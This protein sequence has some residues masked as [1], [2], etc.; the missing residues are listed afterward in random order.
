ME[1]QRQHAPLSEIIEL[2]FRVEDQQL[3]TGAGMMDFLACGLGGIRYLH[4][5]GGVGWQ[6]DVLEVASDVCIVLVDTLTPHR[7][8]SFASEKRRRFL[9]RDSQVLEYA[10]RTETIVRRLRELM[11]NPGANMQEVGGAI[12]E[13]HYNLRTLM[14][15]STEL[16]DV[17]VD[18]CNRN[19][20]YGAKLT[21][22]GMGGCM[23]ALVPEENLH[24]VV[25]ALQY[26]P[27]TIYQCMF[28]D[29]LRSGDPSQH[30]I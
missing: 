28:T 8:R 30:D 19:G 18:L 25:A 5:V 11:R 4:H 7:T 6:S 13:C 3:K 2:A 9:A 12:S 21:G 17:C 24:R 20:A 16:L 22:S 15:C 14:H 23:F 1:H 26:L 27:I 29:G 10:M